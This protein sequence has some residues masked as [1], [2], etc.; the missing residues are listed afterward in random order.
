MWGDPP[1]LHMKALLLTAQ[2][3]RSLP[4]IVQ[5]RG[6]YLMSVGEAYEVEG[7]DKRMTVDPWLS[8]EGKCDQ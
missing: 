5:L 6:L 1:C 4:G 2:V 7:A 8:D 3:W